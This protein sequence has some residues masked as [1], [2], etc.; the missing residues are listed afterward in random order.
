[1]SRRNR[2][3]RVA[4]RQSLRRTDARLPDIHRAASQGW[5]RRQPLLRSRVHDLRML[6][7]LDEDLQRHLTVLCEARA[8][9]VCVP[10]APGWAENPA[11][12]FVEAACAGMG[13][14]D[15]LEEVVAEARSP[16]VQTALGAALAWLPFRRITPCLRD[17]HDYQNPRWRALALGACVAHR[18]DPGLLIDRGLADGDLGVRIHAVRACGVFRRRDLVPALFASV[19][20]DP[21]DATMELSCEVSLLALGEAEAPPR[22]LALATAGGPNAEFATELALRS[23]PVCEAMTRL[24]IMGRHRGTERCVVL[25]AAA[26]GAGRAVP[27][28]LEAMHDPKLAALA[29]YGL[30]TITG[31]ELEE[32]GLVT[33]P[34]DPAD[35]EL[36]YPNVEGVH[37]WWNRHRYGFC[38]DQRW[39]FGQPRNAATL[40]EVLRAECQHQRL[41]AAHDLHHG[42][43]HGLFATEAPGWRQRRALAALDRA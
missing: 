17:W 4:P 1:M 34:H 43:S 24:D 9:G 7:E 30:S 22:L 42:S 26:T 2:R 23:M 27:L 16:S 29:A 33:D 41:L 20:M 18:Q 13:E 21:H 39:C 28:L 6:A 5:A 10:R 19:A 36:P 25:G 11:V 14:R 3:P 12:V 31:L 40:L 35:P 37:Q 38:G 8:R 15:A 32:V